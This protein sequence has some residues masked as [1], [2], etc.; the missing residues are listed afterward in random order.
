M[1]KKS[2]KASAATKKASGMSRNTAIWIIIGAAALAALVFALTTGAPKTVG[3]AP[4]VA[5]LGT[6]RPAMYEFSTDS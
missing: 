4:T 2:A 1:S 5:G 3:S 6:G